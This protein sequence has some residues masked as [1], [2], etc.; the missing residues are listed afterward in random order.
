LVI[1]GKLPHLSNV[2]ALANFLETNSVF[3]EKISHATEDFYRS[4]E[5]AKKRGGLRK[6]ESPSPTLKA[7]QERIYEE[8]LSKV[9]VHAS[10]HGFASGKS[11]ITNAKAHLGQREFLHVDIQEFF[12]SISQFRTRN[13]FLALSFPNAVADALASICCFRGGLPQ[14][15]PSSPAISNIC[16]FHIDE[17][18]QQSAE[19]N[20]LTYTR[21]SD[22]ITFSGSHISLRY[23]NEVD[24]IISENG[25]QLNPAKTLLGRNKGKHIVTGISVSRGEL[26]LPKSTKRRIRKDAFYLMTRDILA[27]SQRRRNFDPLYVDRILGQLSFWISVEPD[28]KFAIK[29]KETIVSKVSEMRKQFLLE[30]RAQFPLDKLKFI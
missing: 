3:L 4:F 29:A 17:Q 24:R 26:K 9:A 30:H 23:V 27:E 15:A 16:F 13:I 21:Y 8:I 22:D 2:D 14:G 18:I 28:A 5:I 10:A 19:E 6:I 25:F 11:I 20:K 12:P 7:F 1:I